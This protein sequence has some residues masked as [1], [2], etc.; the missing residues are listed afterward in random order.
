[1]NKTSEKDGDDYGLVF[2]YNSNN[3]KIATIWV[4]DDSYS[5]NQY[6]NDKYKYYST[7]IKCKDFKYSLE[8]KEY[9]EYKEDLDR[10]IHYINEY[11]EKEINN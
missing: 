9:E 7:T 11:F 1:M 5:E 3:E 4:I 6:V 2:I 10:I 8:S